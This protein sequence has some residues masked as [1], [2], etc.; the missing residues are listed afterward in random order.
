M[1]SPLQGTVF[2]CALLSALLLNGCGSRG[3]ELGSVTGMVTLDNQPLPEATVEFQPALGSPSESITDR[4]GT[5]TLR[6]T[7]KRKGAMLGT[8]H[9]R[10][11]LST[12]TDVQGQKIDVPQLLPARYNRHSELTAEVKP[13]SNKFDFALQSR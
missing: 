13:G 3:L 1:R 6:Y 9:V 7:A 10:I 4:S 2:F 8:H 11:T 5:Y 12:R